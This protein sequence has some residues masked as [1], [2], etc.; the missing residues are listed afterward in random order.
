MVIFRSIKSTESAGCLESPAL[1]SLGR[2]EEQGKHCKDGASSSAD[3]RELETPNSKRSPFLFINATENVANGKHDME[4][5]TLVRSHVMTTFYR[6]RKAPKGQDKTSSRHVE[7]GGK[8]SKFKLET[9][10]QRQKRRRRKDK[11]SDTKQKCK[12]Q[13]PDITISIPQNLPSS[14]SIDPFAAAVLPWD[15]QM[16][17]LVRHCQSS[18]SPPE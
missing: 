10:P 18:A 17:N 14:G 5:R 12:Q 11:A 16:Q 3:Q 9:Y 15:S 1:A 13:S 4:S 2:A 8:M 7:N 6:R